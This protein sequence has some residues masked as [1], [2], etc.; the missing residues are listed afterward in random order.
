MAT[1]SRASIYARVS[2]EKLSAAR[3][4]QADAAACP[5]LLLAWLNRRSRNR[6]SGAGWWG[7]GIAG[8]A[9]IRAGGRAAGA[10]AA[11]LGDAAAGAAVGPAYMPHQILLA[12]RV[13][14]QNTSRQ[15]GQ[16]RSRD[17]VADNLLRA[18]LIGSIPMLHWLERRPRPSSTA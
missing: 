15:S 9:W 7:S 18:V 6:P 16:R 2:P 3:P 1:A 17:Q 4:G 8:S 11:D 14:S 13:R 10:V 5:L 12:L